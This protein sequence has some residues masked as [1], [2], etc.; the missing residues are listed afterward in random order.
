MQLT[1]L[2]YKLILMLT[3]LLTFNLG[4]D[5]L[6]MNSSMYFPQPANHEAALV[7]T[8]HTDILYYL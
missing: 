1:K 2:F 8:Y 5:M 6:Y 3:T 7:F 4:Y